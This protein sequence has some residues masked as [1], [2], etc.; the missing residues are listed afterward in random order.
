MNQ[1]QRVLSHIVEFINDADPGTH[2]WQLARATRQICTV[3]L[4]DI[5]RGIP[6]N[7]ELVSRIDTAFTN[8]RQSI[9]NMPPAIDRQALVVSVDLFVARL[10][11]YRRNPHS[12]VARTRAHSALDDV[13]EEYA[14]L[15][16]EELH[17]V[18]REVRDAAR[19]IH[20]GWRRW[21][22]RGRNPGAQQQR[23][24]RD[25]NADE[26]QPSASQQPERERYR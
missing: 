10:H 9:P 19:E 20:T 12:L 23:R 8:A 13:P 25:D 11:H 7:F 21:M 26:S 17:E 24:H 22:E 6:V 3:I 14:T 18:I 4:D 16:A 2:E 5:A 15:P 1:A